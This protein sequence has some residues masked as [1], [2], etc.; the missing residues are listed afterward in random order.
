MGAGG[1]SDSSGGASAGGGPLGF[2]SNFFTYGKEQDIINTQGELQKF[3]QPGKY[4][5]QSN[6]ELLIIAVLVFLLIAVLF[7]FRNK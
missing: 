1:G 6:T 7:F 4:N 2:F 5:S 3:F